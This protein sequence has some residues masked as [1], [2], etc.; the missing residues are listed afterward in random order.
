MDKE[1]CYI[2][3][4]LPEKECQQALKDFTF[5]VMRNH[6][7]VKWDEKSKKHVLKNRFQRQHDV[8]EKLIDNY[9]QLFTIQSEACQNQWHPISEGAPK[10][11]FR[12]LVQLDNSWQQVAFYEDGEWIL[13]GDEALPVEND[14]RKVIAWM[15]L[16]ESYREEKKR[17][18]D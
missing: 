4:K 7:N 17:L 5:E 9:C 16:P 6:N 2:C 1:E 12:V 15:E 13:V 18:D 10:H 14:Y 11:P 8:L 3:I